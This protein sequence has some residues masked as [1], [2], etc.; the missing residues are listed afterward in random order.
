ME[1][2]FLEVLIMP[3]NEI[4]FLDKSIGFLNSKT[5]NGKTYGDYVYS[6][7][8]E[9][10][11]SCDQEYSGK[12]ALVIKETGICCNCYDKQCRHQPEENSGFDAVA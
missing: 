8:E 10:C 4:L 2:K 9:R 11:P 12:N 1:I 7:K 6:I 5:E 3:N